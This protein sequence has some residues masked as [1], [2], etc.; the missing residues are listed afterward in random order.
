MTNNDLHLALCE[1]LNLPQDAPSNRVLDAV[2]SRI[3]L[4]LRDSAKFGNTL[5]E[6]TD[7]IMSVENDLASQRKLNTELHAE[8]LKVTAANDSS[9]KSFE[10]YAS[11]SNS[12]ISTLREERDD[13]L[14]TVELQKHD[15][16]ALRIAL[17]SAKYALFAAGNTTSAPR[18]VLDGEIVPAVI[19]YQDD[20]VALL[21][22]DDR[23]FTSA[24]DAIV[25][26][27]ETA[28]RAQELLKTVGLTGSV[29]NRAS[30]ALGALVASGSVQLLDDGVEADTGA[31]VAS[32]SVQLCEGE[33][34]EQPDYVAPLPGQ[35][36]MPCELRPV[37]ALDGLFGNASH[38]FEQYNAYIV[39]TT[40]GSDNA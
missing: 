21:R 33:A 12:I 11:A 29:L 18:Y 16:E 10:Q 17:D 13:A 9:K 15:I 36:D 32:G 14:R 23:D 7:K 26:S 19:L 30:D 6:Y 22:T 40:E 39:P 2:K 25:Y 20:E 8:L 1:A 37:T 38:K 24:P 4:T 28:Y 35:F 5:G 27:T 34:V 31:L 3:D